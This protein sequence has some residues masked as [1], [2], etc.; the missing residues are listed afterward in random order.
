MMAEVARADAVIVNPTH[1][2]VAI[3]YELAKGA[4]RVIAKGAD[5]AALAI[6]VEAARHEVPLIEDIPLARTLWDLCEPGDEIPIELYEAVARVLA[7]LFRVKAA[8]R[9][10]PLGG[11]P[12]KLPVP[13][14]VGRR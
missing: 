3:R 10:H 12:L 9:L 6:R 11:G 7:F 1:V 5:E 14:Q 4:P 2:S 8:G 13:T